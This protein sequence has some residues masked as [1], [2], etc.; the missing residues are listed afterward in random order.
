VTPAAL[1]RARLVAAIFLGGCAGGLLRHRVLQAWPVVD[2]AVPWP[3]VVV[4]AAGAFVLGLVLVAAAARPGQTLL[5]PLLAT[6]FCGALTTFSTVV[7]GAD[8]L[9]ASGAVP[10]AAVYVGASVVSG[11]AAVAAGL[12]L[13][14]TVQR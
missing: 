7:V 8:E 13:G 5:R 2:D 6:G 4:N 10:A 11:L 3:V 14:R 9:I 12:A 1:G